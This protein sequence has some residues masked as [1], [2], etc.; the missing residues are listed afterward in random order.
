[1]GVEQQHEPDPEQPAG[2]AAG[3]P[4]TRARS[5]RTPAPRARRPASTSASPARSRSGTG[6]PP[7]D[8]GQRPR[9]AAEQG[10]P[11]APRHGHREQGEQQLG[12]AAS[13]PRIASS[14]RCRAPRRSDRRSA[15]GREISSATEEIF[16]P[17]ADRHRQP[18]GNRSNRHT[19]FDADAVPD[20]RQR[21]DVASA[22]CRRAGDR[23]QA[24]HRAVSVD[25]GPSVDS[26]RQRFARPRSCSMVRAERSGRSAPAPCSRERRIPRQSKTGL[27]FSAP[28]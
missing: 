2:A 19:A 16:R 23:Q 12:A 6:S 3:P 28:R 14:H 10:V 26:D 27:W 24:H 20:Q 18:G 11:R 15:Q 4:R 9:A 21:R 25:L 1:M 8:G 13:L 5:S 7:P 17:C 22:A